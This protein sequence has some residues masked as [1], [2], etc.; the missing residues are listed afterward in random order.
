[1]A[2][3]NVQIPTLKLNDGTSIPLIGY[4]TGTAWYKS[5]SGSGIDRKLVDAT[6]T[7]LKL[8]YYHLDAAEVYNTEAEVGI[9]IKES[10]VPREKLFVTTKVIT[11]IQDVPNAINQSLEKLQLDYVD[12]YLVHSPF[13]ASSDAD[14]QSTWAAMEKVKADGKA[15]SIGVSNYL[16]PHLEATMKTASV[17]PSINQ[18]EYHPYLQHGGPDGPL[19]SYMKEHNI[20]N[21][22][23]APLTAVTKA[24]PGPL[25]ELYAHLAKKYYVSE[26]EIA[27]RWCIDQNVVAITTSGKE[28]RLSDYLRATTFTMT[29]KEN[30]PWGKKGHESLAASLCAKTPNTGFEIDESK[31]YAEMW[32]GD[33][34]VLPAKGLKSGEELHKIVDDNKEQLLGK[35][36]IDKFGGVVPFLPKILSI[37]KAL[38]LQIHPNKELAAQLHKQDPEKFTD[39]NHKPE[40]AIAL[41]P[42]EVFA[43]F[44]DN[45]DIQALFSA[46]SP[47]ERFLPRKDV[48]FDHEV[49]KQVCYKI[50]TASDE[51]IR[52][53]Q[54]ELAKIPKEKYGKQAY[55]VDLLPRLQEQY[56]KEDPGNLVALLTMNFLS[57]TAGEAI[58]VP[59][60]APHAYLSGNIVECMARSNN[61]LN[62]GFCP[63]ADADSIELFTSALTF[64]PH[65][66][67][68]VK[69]GTSKTEK[70]MH[71]KTSVYAPPMSEFNML[72]T[73]LQDGEK[74]TIRAIGGPSVLFATRGSGKL[75]ADG[76][77]HDIK[78]GYIFFVGQGVEVSYEATSGLDVY[79]AYAE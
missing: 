10:K 57:L 42:F 56:S 23:Y 4:G 44:K 72:K 39:P 43:G 21:S 54:V 70:S 34:P 47:L 68:E 55:I 28:E 30:Y 59:A 13:F 79:Q 53:T 8:G 78:E 37:S 22:A 33:Y 65:N 7:A 6:K 24:K 76:D 38:P 26:G 52:T 31:E 20:A 63:R 67:E 48:N 46:L 36:C 9:A 32:M 15:K 64:S 77:T 60:D 40:I 61:V 71:G 1:M 35:T 62:T 16:V 11:N 14:L 75:V 69:L 49:L 29:P 25:D 50:F 19:L 51:E 41:G 27:L 45:N 73:S 5:D 17:I 12:L 2:N 74:E 66:A 18:I 3:L 58:Y